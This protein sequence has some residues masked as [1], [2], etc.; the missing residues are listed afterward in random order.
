MDKMGEIDKM[1]TTAGAGLQPVPYQRNARIT[2]P[3]EQKN[4]VNLIN[5]NKIVV[6]TKGLRVK[7]AMTEEGKT[8]IQIFQQITK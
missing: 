8:N 7:P 4:L 1:A 6:Q 3:R 5:L 2:N